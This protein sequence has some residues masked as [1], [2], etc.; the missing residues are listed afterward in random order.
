MVMRFGLITAMLAALAVGGCSG[1]WGN[2]EFERYS[3]RNDAITMSAGDAKEVNAATHMYHPW[4]RGVENRQ[5]ATDGPRMQRALE[6][7]RRGARPNDPLPNIG[8]EGTTLGNVESLPTEPAPVR[9]PVIPPPGKAYG[10]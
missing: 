5:I 7:Y 2:D 9:P 10:P 4:P 8:L 3:Q 1:L 6:R